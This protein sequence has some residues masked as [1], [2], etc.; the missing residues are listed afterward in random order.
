MEMRVLTGMVDMWAHRH[1]LSSAAIWGISS[2]AFSVLVN[3][4]WHIGKEQLCGD[5]VSH[6]Q[7]S[8]FYAPAAWSVQL[9]AGS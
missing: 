5:T 9:T 7:P 6:C 4:A 1:V 2:S 3:S 8:L